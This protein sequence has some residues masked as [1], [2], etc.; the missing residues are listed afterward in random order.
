MRRVFSVKS[1]SKPSPQLLLE[2]DPRSRRG[3]AT[4]CAGAIRPAAGRRRSGG[5]I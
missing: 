4:A 2:G 3:D 5:Q 1:R